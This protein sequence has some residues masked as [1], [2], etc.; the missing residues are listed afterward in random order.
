MVS[1]FMSN[2]KV[3]I[4]EKL[5]TGTRWGVFMVAN[6]HNH[7]YTILVVVVVVVLLFKDIIFIVFISRVKDFFILSTFLCF[8]TESLVRCNESLLG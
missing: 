5:A 4:I 8:A 6:L 3:D 7:S 1:D 2:Y